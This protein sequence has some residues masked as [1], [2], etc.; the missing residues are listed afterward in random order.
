MN[1]YTISHLDT[2]LPDYFNGHHKTVLQVPVWQEMTKD[3]LTEQIISEYNMCYDHFVEYG[4]WP[5]LT[6]EQ[7]RDMC[8]ELILTDSPFKDTDI[9]TLDDQSDDEF[10]D[11]V[12]SFFVCG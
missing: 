4:D 12:Y 11:S 7:L 8:D 3:E 6:D 10:N 2:C 5:D 9:P 1:D